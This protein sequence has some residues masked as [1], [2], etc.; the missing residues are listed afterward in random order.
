MSRRVSGKRTRHGFTLI[1]IMITV[2]I[3]GILSAIALPMMSSYIGRSR[4]T[5]AT[6]FLAEIK[7]RQEA[8]RADF[9]CYC[10]VSGTY[11][12]RW[13]SGAPGPTARVWAA[14]AAWNTLGAVPPGRKAL[15]SYSTVAGTPNELPVAYGVPDSRGYVLG[16]FWFI[17]SA[18]GDLDGDK[19]FMTV[20]SYSHSKA[21]WVSTGD[22]FE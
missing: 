11:G 6:G 22:G 1:E 7:S 12:N 9:G 3:L 5:E 17:S 18:Q 16:D 13:P 21:N 15:F 2:A 10:N 14:N 20:E 19:V 8:Y 4:V